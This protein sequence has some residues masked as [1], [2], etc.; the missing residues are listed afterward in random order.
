MN[1]SDAP[2]ES[3][4][5]TPGLCRARPPGE[6]SGGAMPGRPRQLRKIWRA[7]ATRP[8]FGRQA[9]TGFSSDGAKPPGHAFDDPVGGRG[10]GADTYHPAAVEPFG[11]QLLLRLDVP[12]ERLD[13]PAD[14][15]EVPRVGAVLPAHDHHRV[16]LAG[17]LPGVVLPL[18]RVGADG[19]HRP[20][21]LV[22]EGERS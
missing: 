19:V 12:G 17:E 5:L 18:L 9:R 13:A 4:V 3:A 1:C 22:P 2:A 7:H 16:D 8:N 11:L 10:P 6:L 20:H 15:G 14:L 21:L